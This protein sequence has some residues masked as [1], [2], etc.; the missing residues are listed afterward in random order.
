M[1][2]ELPRKMLDLQNHKSFNNIHYPKLGSTAITIYLIQNY[3]LESWV[4][5]NR[6][7]YAVTLN[8]SQ[9]LL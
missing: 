1:D 9:F 5:P 8:P 7:S 3:D 2:L 4:P 6:G